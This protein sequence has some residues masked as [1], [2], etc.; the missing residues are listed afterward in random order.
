VFEPVEAIAMAPE[1]WK[2]KDTYLSDYARKA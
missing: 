1:E 2:K